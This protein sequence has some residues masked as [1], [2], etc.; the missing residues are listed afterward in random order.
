MEKVQNP[1][2]LMRQGVEKSFSLACNRTPD[3]QP[4]AIPTEPSRLSINTTAIPFKFAIFV[5]C[6][7]SRSSK[8]PSLAD[9][10]YHENLRHVSPVSLSRFRAN[11]VFGDLAQH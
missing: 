10:S 1:V 5:M 11:T 8:L 2:I 3:A 7:A 9:G 6:S 4:V